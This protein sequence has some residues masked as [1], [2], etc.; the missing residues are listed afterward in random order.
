MVR[1]R[2]ELIR[3]PTMPNENTTNTNGSLTIDL[4]E[5]DTVRL[6]SMLMYI[7]EEHPREIARGWAKK[8]LADIQTDAQIG[9][10]QVNG[11]Q[12]DIDRIANDTTDPDFQAGG[13]ID[14][15][16]LVPERNSCQLDDLLADEEP[17]E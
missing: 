10:E 14:D 4:N 12:E 13:D 15:E 8:L 16:E 7:E 3:N 5:S 6:M 17:A 9:T 2:L 11:M 1:S